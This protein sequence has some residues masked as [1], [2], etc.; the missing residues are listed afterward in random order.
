MKTDIRL[1]GV[2]LSMYG[3]AALAQSYN[4]MRHIS[5]T[6][7]RMAAQKQPY[8]AQAQQKL[9]EALYS[10]E[11]KQVGNVV[12]CDVAPSAI[13]DE[14]IAHLSKA[15]L[16]SPNHYDWQST[17]G[18]YLINRERY[19]EAILHLKQSLHLLGPVKPFNVRQGGPSN[20]MQIAQSAFS[21]HSILGDSLVKIGRYEEAEFHYRRALQFDP[22]ADW[23]LLGIGN[24]M[25]GEG[26]R[27]QARAA[28]QKIISHS[29]SQ[30][31]YTKQAR[32]K[33][34]KYPAAP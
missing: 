12:R 24:A 10:I 34:E 6:E 20:V 17:L 21:S 1:A 7:R 23:V 18:M 9:A 11:Y 27:F 28:W 15:V 26:K 32:L 8:D 25:N 29:P 3:S 4:D 13:Q 16:L 14:A 33:L 5:V 22:D 31:F 19:Q 2:L 30:T